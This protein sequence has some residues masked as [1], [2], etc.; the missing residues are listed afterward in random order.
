MVSIQP[1]LITV[2]ERQWRRRLIYPQKSPG[3]HIAILH[4]K[5]VSVI[6]LSR[7]QV[8]GNTFWILV[9]LLSVT[10]SGEK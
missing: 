3:I 4:M 9:Y 5:A 10:L 8:P 7:S 2:S 6:L 1:W